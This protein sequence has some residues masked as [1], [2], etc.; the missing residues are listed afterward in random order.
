MPVEHAV[1]AAGAAEMRR[2]FWI[3]LGATLGA[4][5]FRKLS[6]AADKLTPQ[7]IAGG[8]GAGLTDLSYALRDFAAD[9]RGAMSDRESELRQAA[10]LDSGDA[11]TAR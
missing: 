5:I 4:L 10:G 11:Q 8:I 7:G 1:P 3:A 2:L 9:V 6:R